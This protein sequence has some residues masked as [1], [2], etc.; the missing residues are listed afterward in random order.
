[1]HAPPPPACLVKSLFTSYVPAIKASPPDVE[2][3]RLVPLSYVG[4]WASVPGVLCGGTGRL[5]R[6]LSVT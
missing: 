6:L 5:Y 2:M 1:M 3:A 4:E